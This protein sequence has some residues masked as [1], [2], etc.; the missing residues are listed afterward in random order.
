MAEQHGRVVVALV[1]RH[2]CER[3]HVPARPLREQRRLAVARRRDDRDERHRPLDAEPVDERG[4]ARRSS[5]AAPGCAASRRRRR[6]AAARARRARRASCADA[7]RL[8]HSGRQIGTRG[9]SLC[10]SGGAIRR[11]ASRDGEPLLIGESAD[12][13]RCTHHRRRRARTRPRAWRHL[14]NVWRTYDPT[15][16]QGRRSSAHWR[17]AGRP[18]IR[19]RR[20][21]ASSSARTAPWSARGSSDART[22]RGH[23]GRGRLRRRRD[24]ARGHRPSTGP[25]SCSPTSA[26]RRRTTDE[27]IRLAVELR[28]ADP[29]SASSSSASTSSPLYALAL[30]EGGSDRPRLPAEGAAAG[31]DELARDPRGRRRRLGRR[32]ARRRRARRRRAPRA[33]TR[34]C[35]S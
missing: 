31:R 28:D 34:R 9:G 18:G 3:P 2:P 1:E 19:R 23:R 8:R 12:P 33:A 14:S 17:E 30:L 35:A 16:V 6:A 29:R 10:R 4:P 20:G 11:R 7:A 25:T 22:A 5:G 27:G 32:P 24:P 13:H 26:C 15:S 21:C